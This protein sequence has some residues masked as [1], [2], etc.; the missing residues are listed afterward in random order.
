MFFIVFAQTPP[1]LKTQNLKKKSRR[2]IVAMPGHTTR[3]REKERA[4]ER[5]REREL[6]IVSLFLFVALFAVLE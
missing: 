4:T 1:H 5:E 6:R 3:E 2:L